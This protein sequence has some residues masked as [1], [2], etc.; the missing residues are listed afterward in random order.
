M[1][2]PPLPPIFTDAM[3]GKLSNIVEAIT[4]L[5]AEEQMSILNQV[6][7]KGATLLHWACYRG[8]YDV[9]EYLLAKGMLAE[10]PMT[11]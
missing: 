10:P 6:D 3:Q 11:N 8:Q 4:H 2:A 1:A 7:Y 9:V 5:E